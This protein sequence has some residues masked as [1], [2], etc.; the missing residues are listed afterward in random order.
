LLIGAKLAC[1]GVFLLFL[2]GILSLGS[3]AAFITGNAQVWITGGL[4][5]VALIV[6]RHFKRR[7]TNQND[8]G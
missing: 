7:N 3:V 6:T 5:I 1:C 4:L 2:T 8:N